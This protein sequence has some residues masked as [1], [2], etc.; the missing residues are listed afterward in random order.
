MLEETIFCG[1]R[2]CVV[3]NICRDVKVAPL[4]PSSRLLQDGETPTEP[5]VETIGGGGANSALFAAG[6][7]ADVSF[8][9]KIGADRLGATP[10]QAL[11]DRGVRP[12]L[13]RDAA[14]R[15]LRP[16]VRSMSSGLATTT[17]RRRGR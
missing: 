5:I 3:G 4:P 10:Q 2:L 1:S 7:G 14:G 12:F 17:A 16:T 13:R 9:G 15:R 11:I 8:A 6:L